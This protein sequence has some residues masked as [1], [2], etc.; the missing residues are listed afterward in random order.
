MSVRKITKNDPLH[1][2]IHLDFWFIDKEK[3]PWTYTHYKAVESFT[4]A[5]TAEQEAALAAALAAETP[6]DT[7]LDADLK[8]ALAAVSAGEPGAGR[9]F[10]AAM[11]A[12]E[13]SGAAARSLAFQTAAQALAAAQPYT[14]ARLR[15]GAII[16]SLIP[17]ITEGGKT[18][19]RRG[20]TFFGHSS[21]ILAMQGL[22]ATV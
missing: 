18:R 5:G 12:M 7:E 11:A 21:T 13:T 14:A 6:Q 20:S 9:A 8:A 17:T 10:M 19:S 15:Q 4:S 2:A 16:K 22:A 3:T 1:W